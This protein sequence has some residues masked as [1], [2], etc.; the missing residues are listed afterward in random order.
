MQFGEALNI[1]LSHE[2]G[3]ANVPGDR[4]GETYRGISRVNWPNWPGWQIVDQNKPLKNNQVI[5]NTLLDNLVSIFYKNQFWDAIQADKL[6]ASIRPLVFDFSV[7]SGTSTAVRIL[8]KVL[9]DT[10]GK[11]ILIDGRIG[12]QT[13]ALANQVQPKVLFD[14]YKQ[15]RLEFYSNIVANNPGQKKFLKGWL[16]RLNSFQYTTVITTGLVIFS[17]IAYLAIKSN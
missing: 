15:A 7:N 16:N 6:P 3:Y 8:Q 17:L 1:V 11:K 12:P 10:T 13:I 5:K 2:G 4:G 14:N 9:T